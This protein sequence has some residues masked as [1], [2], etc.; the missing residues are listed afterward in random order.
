MIAYNCLLDIFFF[1]RRRYPQ[2]LSFI[3]FRYDVND[4]KES[5]KNTVDRKSRLQHAWSIYNNYLNSSSRF[6]IGSDEQYNEVIQRNLQNLSI[7]T[8][9]EIDENLFDEVTESILPMLI[10]P[11]IEYLKDDMLKY[12]E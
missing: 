9:S 5:F 4:F 1:F 8:N 6:Q 3:L 10:E 7:S 12:A 11:W 2:Y